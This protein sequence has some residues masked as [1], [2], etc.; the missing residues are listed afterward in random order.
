MNRL[1][2]LFLL[3]GLLFVNL[4][5]ATLPAAAQSTPQ[6]VLLTADG[7]LTPVMVNYVD[8]G[9]T[10]AETSGAEAVVIE[11]NTPGGSITLM[12]DM[13]ARIR[14][15]TVPVIVFVS[16][17][18]SMAG[19]AGTLIT[20]SGHVA[21]M[22]PDTTIGAASPVGSQ[23]ENIDTTEETKVKEMMKAS[24]RNL[25]A[26]RPLAA[27]KLA[28]SMIEEA[29]AV[30][31]DEAL[32]IGLVDI[33]ARS[34]DGLL[35]QLDGRVV[36]LADGDITLHTLDARVVDISPNLLEEALGFL[37]DPNIVFLLLSVG[38]QAVLI[39]LSSPGGWVA[40]FIGVVCLLLAVF[41]LGILPV[42]W[43]GILFLVV[44]FVLFILDIKAPTHGALTTV[45]VIT[46]IIGALVL[47][48]AIRLP[49]SPETVGGPSISTPLVIGT[50]IVLGLSF[51]A[52]VSIALRAQ[53]APVKTGREALPGRIGLVR[54]ELTP[55]G[56]VQVAG[57]L[58]TAR[59]ADGEE[60]LLPG[61]E[62]VVV[63]VDGLEVVVKKFLRK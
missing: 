14:S 34:L 7:A 19:S 16:P 47:F 30:T 58:W 61:A 38:V 48:S 17:A 35:E 28:E 11:L 44:A 3:L 33:K 54:S 57:E 41:G 43:F 51:F 4:A 15:S 23:G 24:A 62:I 46:F 13:T 53:R 29:K 10:A 45:G 56:Q 9:L 20:L 26:D 37:T 32:A 55:R 49:G 25:T 39:E 42:N 8:R 63:E 5:G 6:V 31:V 22:A 40:G 27:Q 1:A 18:G 50:G 59:L 60:P 12:E 36:K 2:R 21:A 52:I